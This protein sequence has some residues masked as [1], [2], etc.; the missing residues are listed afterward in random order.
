MSKQK[1]PLF[2]SDQLAYATTQKFSERDEYVCASGISPSGFVHIGNFREIITTDFVVKSLKYYNEDT[3]FIYSW[4]D[5]DR[6]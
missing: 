2:W 5:Y 3:R 6:F 1:Q 4:D